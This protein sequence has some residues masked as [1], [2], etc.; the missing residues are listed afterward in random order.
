[1]TWEPATFKRA[2][3][4]WPLASAGYVYGGLGICLTSS[5]GEKSRWV[6]I[7]LNSGHAICWI[8]GSVAEAF[9][10]ASDIADCAD[11]TFDGL[12]GWRNQSPDLYER[13]EEVWKRHPKRIERKGDKGIMSEE[14]AREIS[15][16]RA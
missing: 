6:L 11:W 16:D 9:P 5:R 14:I 12:H 15:M 13:F 10:V 7:H 1:M 3:S 8:R 4:S 2:H